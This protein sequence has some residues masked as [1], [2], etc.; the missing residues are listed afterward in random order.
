[1]NSLIVHELSSGKST[2]HN[3]SLGGDR[4]GVVTTLTLETTEGQDN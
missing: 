4:G 3:C 2:F 1:M